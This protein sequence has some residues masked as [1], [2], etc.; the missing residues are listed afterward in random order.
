[1]RK[2]NFRLFKSYFIINLLNCIDLIVKKVLVNKLFKY[3]TKNS[4]LYIGQIGDERRILA[5]Y[6]IISLF[7]TI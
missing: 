5:I 6:L 3:Y 1:M 2:Q 7:Y 4:E